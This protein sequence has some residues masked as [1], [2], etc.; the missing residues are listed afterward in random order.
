MNKRTTEK[1]TFDE[2]FHP[3]PDCDQAETAHSYFQGL[4]SEAEKQ[5][6]QSHLQVCAHCPIILADLE[7]CETAVTS[8]VLDSSRTDKIF[9]QNQKRLFKGDVQSTTTQAKPF[10]A[11][12]Q[13]PAYM[14]AFAVV[15][16]CLMI[17]PSYRSLILTG[18][19]EKLEHELQLTKQLSG[20][21][22]SYQKQIETLNNERASLLEPAVSAS[23]I[24]PVRTERDSEKKIIDVIF[25]DTDKT[26][27][28]VL[29][30]PAEDLERYLLKI[31]Q[32]EKLIWQ[33][34]FPAFPGSFLVSVNLRAGY[35]SP[36]NYRL[37]VYG[38]TG[39]METEISQFQLRIQHR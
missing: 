23:A 9:D 29:S 31:Y 28:V 3:E 24:Y 35:F 25:G 11:S 26:F 21:L 32:L 36:G 7:E 34:E 18:Q 15:L 19:V 38:K 27:S 20:N 16:I 33:K 2:V 17:Y 10:W 5:E 8:V 13:I 12:F 1:F 39:E 6:F 14:T 22:S 4:L 37:Y 30:L